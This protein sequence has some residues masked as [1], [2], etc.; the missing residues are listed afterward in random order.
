[1]KTLYAHS[2][3][4]KGEWHKLEDHL[5]NTALLSYNMCKIE[6]LKDIV[7]MLGLFHDLGKSYQEFQ[8]RL[9]GKNKN[10]FNHPGLSVF[11]IQKRFMQTSINSQLEEIINGHH[12]GL[13][14]IVRKDNKLI[15][16]SFVITEQVDDFIKLLNPHVKNVNQIFKQKISFHDSLYLSGCLFAAD[17]CD[18]SEH[19][20]TY[21]K[22][23]KFISINIEE[24]IEQY[25]NEISK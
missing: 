1:M 14:N 21:Y 3:N 24:S 4:G 11:L 20:Q 9:T 8:D 23:Q 25:I 16:R 22:E 19:F 7:Y 2:A 12:R 13:G 6:R 15:E 17:W 5:L 10:S 18:T